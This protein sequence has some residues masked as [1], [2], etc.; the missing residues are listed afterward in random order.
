MLMPCTQHIPKYDTVNQCVLNGGIV[1]KEAARQSY[2]T[3]A[4][5]RAAFEEILSTNG[6][7]YQVLLIAVICGRINLRQSF[8]YAREHTWC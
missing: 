8:Q 7:P 1:I 2:C 5:S 4:F 3:D 6:I